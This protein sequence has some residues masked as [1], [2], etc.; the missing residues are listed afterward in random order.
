[1]MSVSSSRTSTATTTS[2]PGW[3]CPESTPDAAASEEVTLA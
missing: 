1:M 3:N 2:S